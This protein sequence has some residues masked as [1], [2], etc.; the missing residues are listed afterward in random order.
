MYKLVA[1]DLDGTLVTDD[2]KLTK[3]TIETIKEA[4]EKGVKIMISSG[5]AFYRLEKFV[6]ELGLRKEDQCTICFNG[7]MIVDNISKEILYSKNLEE[8]EVK[9]L[10]QLG[11]SLKLPIMIYGK[12]THYVEK[13]PEVVQEN[14]K[15]L[16]GM[17]LKVVNFD[18][19]NFNE[20]QNHIYKVCFIDKPE[21]IVEKRKE[22]SKEMMQKYEITS[23]V[24]EYLEIVKKGIKKSEAIKFVMEKYAIKQDEVMAIGD[25]END[26]EMLSFAGLGI[27]MENAREYVK[28][29]A[30]DVTTSNNH[31]GV[32]NAI[33]KYILRENRMDKEFQILL[34]KAKKIAKKRILNEY[35]SCGHCGCAL[36][37][38][39]GNIYTGISIRTK[40]NLGKCAE[41]A[42]IAEMLKHNESEIKKLVSYSAKDVIY[43][44]CGSCRELIRMVDTKN[45]E[46]EIMVSENKVCKLKELLPEMFISKH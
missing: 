12:D 7:G 14:K 8:E 21:T 30:N 39:K 42:A 32:A 15:N 24:P 19:L 28:E 9:E 41:Y 35:A 29:F 16:K 3:K 20:K 6:D 11:R 2:K 45:L 1:I 43:S 18:E 4:S 5:R 31:D 13:V 37:T 38:A 40:C 33:E 25:G 17:H 10:I 22:I 44:P 23:S 27:A 26:V 46:T 34:E 36:M